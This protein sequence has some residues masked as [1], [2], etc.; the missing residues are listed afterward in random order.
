MDAYI[1][2]NFTKHGYIIKGLPVKIGHSVI[3]VLKGDVE[4]LFMH[5]IILPSSIEISQITRR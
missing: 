5:S 2:D 3:Q 4:V 1:H